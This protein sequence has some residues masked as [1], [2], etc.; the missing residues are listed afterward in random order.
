MVDDTVYLSINT[1]AVSENEQNY[2]N[3]RWHH[4]ERQVGPEVNVYD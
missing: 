2:K 3:R 1:K 4:E